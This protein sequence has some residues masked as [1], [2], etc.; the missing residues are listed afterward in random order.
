[1]TVKLKRLLRRLR[2]TL[3][4]LA[5]VAQFAPA[6]AALTTVDGKLQFVICT[7]DGAKSVSWGRDDRRAVAF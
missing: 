7:A 3:L 2:Q 1:M 6:N 5:V 4:L